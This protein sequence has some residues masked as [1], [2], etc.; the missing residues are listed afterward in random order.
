[1]CNYKKYSAKYFDFFVYKIL[2]SMTFIIVQC[3]VLPLY[4]EQF[5]MLRM[6][7]GHNL[8]QV[9]QIIFVLQMLLHDCLFSKLS[10]KQCDTQ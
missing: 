7:T 4:L 5:N 9:K 6:H 10:K 2:Q 3:T 8:H 1:M